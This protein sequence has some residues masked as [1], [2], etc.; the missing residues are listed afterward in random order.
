MSILLGLTTLQSSGVLLYDAECFSVMQHTIGSSWNLTSVSTS[1]GSRLVPS[2]NSIY[3]YLS[4]LTRFFLYLLAKLS[5]V[6]LNYFFQQKLWT[7]SGQLPP[8]T[9]P[10]R[11]AINSTWSFAS[12][13]SLCLQMGKSFL[14]T[15]GWLSE[16]PRGHF[17][18]RARLRTKFISTMPLT[19]VLRLLYS[20]STFR[21]TLRTRH[22]SRQRLYHIARFSE[23]HYRQ[24]EAIGVVPCSQPKFRINLSVHLGIA[25]CIPNSA[26]L[27]HFCARRWLHYQLPCTKPTTCRRR[28]QTP[29][30]YHS[31]VDRIPVRV[32]RKR[33][34]AALWRYSSVEMTSQS[35]KK[36]LMN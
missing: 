12:D 27:C 31:L 23:C 5:W 29:S 32:K 2:S 4:C 9:R 16:A 28:Y 17:R 35:V 33:Y 25:Y 20:N 34:C 24:F 10:S 13:V 26:N 18:R 19:P 3:T 15:Q 22:L 11:T 7:K 1:H 30:Q 8:K 36:W 14:E 21:S 6:L